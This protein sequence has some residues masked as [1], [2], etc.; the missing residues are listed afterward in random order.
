MQRNGCPKDR[1]WRVRFFSAP[2]WSALETSEN[3]KVAEKKRTL[4]KRSFGQPFLRTTPS[5]LIW[6]TPPKT[7]N[8]SF[9]RIH[10]TRLAQI[11]ISA[12]AVQLGSEGPKRG[13]LKMGFRSVQFALDMSILT[14]ISKTIPQGKCHLERESAV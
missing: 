10:V 7:W 5:L 14:A 12:L 6:R 13:P 1:F 11:R 2:L 3:F 9:E 4:Q 8:L